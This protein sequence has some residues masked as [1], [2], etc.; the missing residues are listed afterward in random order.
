[1]LRSGDC[2]ANLAKKTIKGYHIDG[3]KLEQELFNLLMKP[4]GL[5]ESVPGTEP[6]SGGSYIVFDGSASQLDGINKLRGRDVGAVYDLSYIFLFNTF[7]GPQTNPGARIVLDETRALAL[8]HETIHLFNF[9]DEDFSD[10]GK[11]PFGLQD[12]IIKSCI[13]PHYDHKDTAF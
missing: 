12:F 7:F 5:D 13:N 6:F 3:D 4:E 9:R 10:N 1:M 11:D 2:K 8:L